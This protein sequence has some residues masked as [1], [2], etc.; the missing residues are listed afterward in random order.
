MLAYNINSCIIRTG[1]FA[2][3][4]AVCVS[5]QR[6][7]KVAS[8]ERWFARIMDYVQHTVQQKIVYFCGSDPFLAPAHEIATL[9]QQLQINHCFVIV[10]S[11]CTFENAPYNSP[12]LLIHIGP[13]E[14]LRTRYVED[15]KEV[16][17][18]ISEDEGSPTPE[19]LTRLRAS[20]P[21]VDL[22]PEKPKDL[23][24]TAKLI[25]KL[26]NVRLSLPPLIIKD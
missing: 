20:L 13:F 17:V 22:R 15:R 16:V 12:D 2:N 3:N 5:Q 25:T 7:S 1:R 24:Y 6:V 18:M 9:I 8:T 21:T 26:R 10:E 14:L 19:M 11:G 4:Q 23:Q